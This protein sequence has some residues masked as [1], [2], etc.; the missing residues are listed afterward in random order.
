MNIKYS[1]AK[2]LFSPF[3]SWQKLKVQNEKAALWKRFKKAGT[4]L[5]IAEDYIIH[6]PQYMEIGDNFNAGARFRM[7]AWDK[8]GNASFNPNIKIGNNVIFNTDIH[9][10]CIN[11]IEIGDNCLFASRI[12]ITD[13]HHGDT[14]PGMI[15]LPP[16]KRPLVSKG[17]VKLENNVWIGEGVA[18]MPG[19]TIGEN[20]IIGTNAVVTKD[21]PK[22]SV[23]AGIP[24][25][26]IKTLS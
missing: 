17:A 1:L 23:A 13:H 4:N 8:F 11:S 20:S 5:F 24:A 12:Y 6:N 26:V 9:I 21:I 7:E 22:N 16:S 18:I 3:E 2:L 25:K 15:A 19:V 10:G 14:T